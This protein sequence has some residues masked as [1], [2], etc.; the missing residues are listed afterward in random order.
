VPVCLIGCFALRAQETAVAVP[1]SAGS[2]YLK[3]NGPI[4]GTWSTTAWPQS[5][6]LCLIASLRA[7]KHHT[8]F[9]PASLS[10]SDPRDAKA[11]ALL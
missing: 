8:Q 6:K 5:G 3:L 11:L 4:L 7:S 10:V 1:R 2:L 9:W